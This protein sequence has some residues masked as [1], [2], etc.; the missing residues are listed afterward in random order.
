MLFRFLPPSLLTLLC[1][2][3][4][5][6]AAEQASHLPQ[7]WYE[8]GAGYSNA[9]ATDISV[10]TG[11][12]DNLPGQ[13]VAGQ[14]P[15]RSTTPPV[16]RNRSS[17]EM[18]LMTGVNNA[19]EPALTLQGRV[20]RP[21]T[22]RTLLTFSLQQ[23]SLPSQSETLSKDTSA[24]GAPLM[25]QD[26]D[27]QLTQQLTRLSLD[28]THYYDEGEWHFIPLYGL[29]SRDKLTTAT[30]TTLRRQQRFNEEDNNRHLYGMQV[31]Q[32]HRLPSGW[33]W[34]QQ[35]SGY[36]MADD[37]DKDVTISHATPMGAA[38]DQLVT[39]LQQ[40]QSHLYQWQGNLQGQLNA[41]HQL[42]VD[43]LWQRKD[44]QKQR[45]A[46]AINGSG[47]LIT[48][49]SGDD[50]FT[51]Y[52]Y[53]I[54]VR[55]QIRIR[56]D[57]TFTPGLHLQY[58]SLQGMQSNN[59][60]VER[61]HHDL[62]PSLALSWQATEQWQLKAEAQQW[63]SRPGF[64]QLSPWIEDN[65][66]KLT[67]GNLQLDAETHRR[68]SV[69]ARYQQPTW[70]SS[71]TLFREHADDVI[72]QA[73]TGTRVLTRPLYQWRNVGDGYRY[74]LTLQQGWRPTPRLE[75]GA[76]T[77]WSDGKLHTDDGNTAPF[78][79]QS[80]WR[81]NLNSRWQATSKDQLKLEAQYHD[82]LNKFTDGAEADSEA[83]RWTLNL[84]ARH[85]LSADV[86]LQLSAYNLTQSGRE[87]S[88]QMRDGVSQYE[89]ERIG[90]LYLLGLHTQW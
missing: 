57:V 71:L 29:G 70:N 1:C 81:V 43:S 31:Q 74:G 83:P 19:G 3:S 23:Q 16:R 48:S 25:R 41:E 79:N 86:Y 64:D 12:S 85:Q 26:E 47:M 9:V 38:V 35:F 56:P 77:T 33:Q 34:Q 60:S 39:D 88:K 14:T 89:D 75:L 55:D 42:T 61:Q 13:P 58:S 76:S 69:S 52:L 30:V 80:R 49:D 66:K 67:Q 15:K 20:S 65:Q 32:R 53:R 54:G 82:T 45:L 6:L 44:R 73:L 40:T 84:S 90:A 68:F 62:L 24:A 7:P 2:A 18:M 17:G 28:L 51:E 46:S 78:P 4:P 8:P 87:E 50:D 72:A 11:V 59:G 27:E 22:E 63:L 21:V 10:V 5:L 36:R 37:R